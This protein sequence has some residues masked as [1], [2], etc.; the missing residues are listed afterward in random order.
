M[1]HTYIHILS[2]SFPRQPVRTL[3][4]IGDFAF[5]A[6]QKTVKRPLT[7]VRIFQHLMT[8]IRTGYSA[9][10][11]THALFSLQKETPICGILRFLRAPIRLPLI[12]LPKSAPIFHQPFFCHPPLHDFAIND[13][14]LRVLPH[15][16]RAKLRTG[17]SQPHRPEYPS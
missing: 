16:S 13:F 14:A 1:I 3:V 8:V 17:K 6:R 9:A 4:N 5:F 7:P 15:V 12:R 2:P 10:C 11:Q